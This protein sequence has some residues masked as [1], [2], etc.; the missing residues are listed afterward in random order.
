M[1]SHSPF[2]KAVTLLCLAIWILLSIFQMIRWDT[3]LLVTLGFL[4]LALFWA[5]IVLSMRYLRAWRWRR[6]RAGRALVGW[7][8]IAA[9]GVFL[10]CLIQATV[11]PPSAGPDLRGRT[12][13]GRHGLP[14][15]CD[16]G[17][18]WNGVSCRACR[19][20]KIFPF[21]RRVSI[22]GMGGRGPA[23]RRVG[24]STCDTWAR[25]TGVLV[26][27]H[28]EGRARKAAGRDRAQSENDG[29]ECV[30]PTDDFQ[31]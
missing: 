26:F 10:A 18:R 16:D 22:P 17:R 21:V 30:G 8:G 6:Q 24:G 14:P 27:D 13:A 5:L 1:S 28:V 3:E 19:S 29:I 12:G 7:T 23:R 15:P 4:A 2:R 20:A 25:G 11:L 9:A 31:M